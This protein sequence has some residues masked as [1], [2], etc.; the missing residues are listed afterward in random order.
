MLVSTW[1]VV[2]WKITGCYMVISVLD[3]LGGEGDMVP[4]HERP[5]VSRELRRRRRH[6][7]RSRAV[8]CSRRTRYRPV[9]STVILGN[10][11]SLPNKMDELNDVLMTVGVTLGTSL[12]KNRSAVRTS[13]FVSMRPCYLPREFSQVIVFAVY[14]PLF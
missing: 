2:F 3:L 6:G 5:D 12:L 7:C 9:L 14:N 13:N 8:R 11:R 1:R 4:P 10:V